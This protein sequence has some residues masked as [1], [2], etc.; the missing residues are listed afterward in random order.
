MSQALVRGDEVVLE[1]SGFQRI[2]GVGNLRRQW[3][4]TEKTMVLEDELADQGD[5]K[6]SHR[7]SRRLLTPLQAEAGSG[8]VVLRG[9]DKTFHLNSPDA[10]AAISKTTLWHAY[11]S[12]RPGTLIEFTAD[13]PLPWS[14]EIRLELL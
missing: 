11:G 5:H 10:P 1:H 12:G 3:R 2:M 6:G 7:V 4:F 13:V 14:G 8:G 9:A